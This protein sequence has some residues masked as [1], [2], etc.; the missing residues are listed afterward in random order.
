MGTMEKTKLRDD[1]R[2]WAEMI[3]QIPEMQEAVDTCLRRH[4]AKPDRDKRRHGDLENLRDLLSVFQQK[5]A[6]DVIFVLNGMG[7]LYFNELRSALDDVNPTTLSRRLK[8]LEQLG[9]VTRDVEQ[10]QP[11]RVSYGITAKG[12]G[13]FGLLLPMLVYMQHAALFDQTDVRELFGI[14]RRPRS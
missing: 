12:K 4:L 11:V 7:T 14:P 3:V 1:F 5:Y 6:F 10:A 13:T 2:E 8:E 9:Y